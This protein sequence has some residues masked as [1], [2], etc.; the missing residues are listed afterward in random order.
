MHRRKE[1]ESMSLS[2][3]MNSELRKA[4]SY[5]ADSELKPARGHTLTQ[6]YIRKRARKQA[7]KCVR[8]VFCGAEK[9]NCDVSHYDSDRFLYYIV[10]I[11]SGS[12]NSH[13]SKH[14]TFSQ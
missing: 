11:V 3:S 7:R 4:R 14:M 13:E 1:F 6:D 12:L 5:T 10:V 8:Y 9:N 2:V